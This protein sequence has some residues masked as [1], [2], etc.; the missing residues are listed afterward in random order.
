MSVLP[1]FTKDPIE[2]ALREEGCLMALLRIARVGL[3]WASQKAGLCIL[4]ATRYERQ[5][6]TWEKGFLQQ[7][8]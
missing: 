8:F 5:G 4:T 1:L 6:R 7:S 2:W 3:A